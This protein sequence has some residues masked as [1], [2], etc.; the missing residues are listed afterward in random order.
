MGKGL[1]AF[2]HRHWCFFV[3]L[4]VLVLT[5]CSL[6]L[7]SL[8]RTQG[9]LI[10]ALDDAYIHMAMAK[11]L[12]EHGVW[13]VTSDGF[14]S[15]S[16]SPLW[17]LLLAAVYA[18]VGVNTTSPLIMTLVSSC[19]VLAIAYR[20]LLVLRTPP[21]V[22]LLALFAVIFLT[23]LPALVFGGMEHALQTA[24][25]L[26]GTFLAAQSL[27]SPEPRRDGKLYFWLLALAP[28]IT[29]VRF[30]GMFLVAVVS[31]GFFLRRQ[32][33]RGLMF[34]LLGLLPIAV[35]GVVSK[36]H[37]WSWFPASVLLKTGFLHAAA[38]RFLVGDLVDRAAVNL[39]EGAHLVALILFATLL[40]LAA[41]HGEGWAWNTERIMAGIFVGTGILH[42]GF[43]GV[44]WFYRY[45]AYLVALGIL[46]VTSRFGVLARVLGRNTARNV[47]VHES[48]FE[49]AAAFLLVI[50]LIFCLVRG[51]AA[52][53]DIPQAAANVYEQQ[54]QMAAFVKRYYQHS[55][56]ALNDIG[57]VNFIADIHCLDLW[58]LATPTVTRLRL[59]GDYGR[60][61][62][63]KL[64]MDSEA[65]VAIVHD[66]YFRDIGGMPPEWIR[67]GQWQIHNK[68]VGGSDT[69]SFYSLGSGE[70]EPLKARLT[71]FS[72][73]LPPGVVQSGLYKQTVGSNR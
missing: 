71:E 23:P 28:F 13:G 36:L 7:A 14:T 9:N 5:V 34:A 4:V 39:V 67:V 45:E 31:L 38:P 60:E 43:A 44:G 20:I 26:A 30:E 51:T 24:L 65:R 8:H 55:T 58:G 17:T 42:L 15:S 61:E 25:T 37:G 63:A 29:S 3:P 40:D 70:V 46:V 62:I 1:T 48:R 18:L 72:T 69:I 64:A 16:S 2:I 32:A 21:K 6:G 73:E 33:R 22:I 41:G 11:N 66:M 49:G 27:S 19:L 53:R 10:Y 50:S 54:F 68:V 56:V 47:G 57:A 59:R 52:V 12:V 35:Y